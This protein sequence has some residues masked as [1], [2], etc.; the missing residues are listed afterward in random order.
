MHNEKMGPSSKK[1]FDFKGFFLYYEYLRKM[2]NDYGCAAAA[3][4][5]IGS[6]GLPAIRK[7]VVTAME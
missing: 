7:T 4:E 6:Q 5:P 1:H 2:Q 3:S